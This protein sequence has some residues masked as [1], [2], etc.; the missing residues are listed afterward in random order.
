VALEPL[1]VQASLEQN[2]LS[3][4]QLYHMA[5]DTQPENAEPWIQLGIFE[6]DVMK[7]ACSAYKDLNQAYTLDRFN[8]EIAQKGGPLDVARVKVNH[9]ACGT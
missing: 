3:A 2:K 7:N 5:V 6:L 1:L 8:P 4:L 9:G